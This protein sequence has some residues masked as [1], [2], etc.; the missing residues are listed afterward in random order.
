MREWELYT[1]SVLSIYS[2]VLKPI[3]PLSV[4]ALYQNRDGVTLCNMARVSELIA[5]KVAG[6]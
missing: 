2:T 1:I 3:S 4:Q 6:Q 5:M